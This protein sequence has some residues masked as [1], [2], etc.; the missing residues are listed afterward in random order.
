MEER[1]A[2]SVLNLLRNRIDITQVPFSDRGSRL[3]VYQ[4]P[5]HSRLLVRLAERLTELRPGLDTYRRRR[6]FI[7][8]LSLVD[9]AGQQ[10]DFEG[11]M[12]APH[13]LCFRTRLGDF[14]LVFQDEHVSDSDVSSHAE[15]ARRIGL[16][17]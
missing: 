15:T 5:G 4:V 7:H 10:L 8:R 16:P 2:S 14:Q 9:E 11:V 17:R 12:T 1:Q 3:L 6:P 13:A